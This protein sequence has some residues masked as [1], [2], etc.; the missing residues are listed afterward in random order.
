M[1]KERLEKLVS[2][3]R[4]SIAYYHDSK[5]AYNEQNCRDEYISPFLECLGWDVQN[6]KG[7]LPQYQ[8]VVS[9]RYSNSAERPDY[10]LTLNGVSRLFVE[11]KKP[12]VDITVDAEP[13]MQTRRYGWNAKHRLSVLTN[14]E[15]LLIYDTTNKPEAGEGASASLF[16]K[17]HYEEY[18]EHFEEIYD[19]IS[20]ESVYSGRYDEYVEQQFPGAQKYQT[21]IDGTFLNQIND[22][23][24]ELGRYL[25]AVDERY[26]DLDR[27]NDEVQAFINQI[28]F[29]RI[30]EDRNLP[31][32]R[33]LK[34]AAKDKEELKRVL[35]QMFK[36]ADKR[37]DSGLFR[38]ENPLFDLENDMIFDMVMSLYYPKTPYLFHIIEPGILG[39]IYES[40]L[41]ERIVYADGEIRLAQKFEY[42]Y[43]SVVSTPQEVVKYMV[44]NTLDKVCIGKTPGE[45]RKLK[46]VD[47][48][49]GSGIFLEE[50]YQYLVDYC[51]QWYAVNRPEYLLELGNGR[52]KLPIEEKRELLVHCIYGVDID[53]HAVEVAKFSLVLKLLEDETEPSV[54]VVNPILPNLDANI[55]HGNALVSRTAL[56]ELDPTVQ[57]LVDIVPFDWDEINGGEKF[58]V[59][60]GNPPYV[61]TEDIKKLHTRKEQKLYNQYQSAY[62]QYDKYFLFMEKALELIKESGYICYIVPNKWIRVESGER[63]RGLLAEQILEIDDFG[64]KQLFA[65]RTIYSSIVTIAGE[66]SERLSCHEVKDL[67]S[68]WTKGRTDAVSI[69]K[70]QLNSQPWKPAGEA[71]VTEPWFITGNQEYYDILE[72]I[73]GKT[74]S[75][76][77]HIDIFNGI[78][79]SA[80]KIYRIDGKEIV[81]E[82][83]QYVTFVKNGKEYTAEKAVLRPY[84]KPNRLEKEALSS[85]SNMK[86]LTKTYN[87]FP[88]DRQGNLIGIKEM[89]TSY[90]KVWAYLLEHKEALRP[91]YLGGK[92]DV[93]PRM[94]AEQWYCYGRR[95][96]ITSLNERVKIIVGVNRKKD[97]PLY[98]LDH[99]NMLIATGGTAGYAAISSKE[100]SP[101][102]L[103][104]IQAWLGHPLTDLYLQIIGSDFEG[105]FIARGTYTLPMVPFV[106]LDFG[107]EEQRKL[108]EN[109]VTSSQKIY[110]INKQLEVSGNKAVCSVLE[111]E[112]KKLIADIEDDITRI[113]Q[114]KF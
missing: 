89:E 93:Q 18:V 59:I 8:E 33:S 46:I 37:Y 66:K 38:E 29:L 98:L 85:Y 27:L 90:P 36:E 114:Q 76:T 12:G 14:F 17:Y 80:E 45:I 95:Q 61:K 49:C 68:L 7:T 71:S 63:L 99:D 30:C 65:E 75:I 82:D 102:A 42:I 103:E 24:L 64:S 48:S 28:I 94:G 13:A 5:N 108:Y 78:Q 52:K 54:K 10:T 50:A 31:L 70:Q 105:E 53:I 110:E 101:Y 1:G 22:W 88:Y 92:R 81:A 9:E 16:R 44:K 97:N 104:Y 111:K 67:V 25:Y 77:E 100:G 35:N 51:T 43:K 23:R 21:E 79:T 15:Y 34:D 4:K 6:T 11:A 62:R 60:L 20:R 39:K 26:Q 41:T 72:G 106:K 109:V 3:Y 96:A 19:L 57:E 83:S 74:E 112:K 58:D 84:F 113:Y 69:P 32:Y 47:P 91:K 2:K 87:I 56:S 55:H 107:Q 73:K 40:F 86:L